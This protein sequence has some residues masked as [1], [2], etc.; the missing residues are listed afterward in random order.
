[1]DMG[2]M[3]NAVMPGV[4]GVCSRCHRPPFQAILTEGKLPGGAFRCG[5][6]ALPCH[7]ERKL[8]AVKMR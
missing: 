6:K 7:R 5:R 1:M 2:R 4:G 3:R 8:L